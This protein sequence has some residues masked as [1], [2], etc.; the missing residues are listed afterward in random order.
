MSSRKVT[1]HPP[2]NQLVTGDFRKRHV[3]SSW[4]PRGT[5]D[6]VLT[7]TIAG[8]GRYGYVGGEMI[9]LP[10][11]L[12]LMRPGTL[13]DYGLEPKLRRWV[14]LWTHFHPRPHWIEWLHW[15]EIAPGLMRLSIE[16]LAARRRI[17]SRFHDVHNLA[18]GPLVRR[19][20]FAMNALEEVL[21]WCDVE[22]PLARRT[23]LDTRV[24]VAM[25]VLCHRLSEKITQTGLAETCGLSASRL[26]H[27]FRAQVGS[28]PQRFLELQRLN[29]AVQ[30]LDS[31]QLSVKE[32]AAQVGFDNPFYFTLRFKR[33]NGVSPR[34][35][36]LRLRGES[37]LEPR[38]RE[39]GREKLIFT[40][41][42]LRD[43]A[44][45]RLI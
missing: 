41:R 10:H 12:V 13:H 25:D 44:A 23:P 26:A 4:R 1:G 38:R 19:E 33:Q 3:Y 36:R 22:N 11:D 20:T 21:L 45:S 6:W 27:L 9:A 5:N 37:R 7:Y 42:Q 2:V 24:R 43:F 30:L 40:S 14:F 31:T 18:T 29:R 16:D 35:Y 17:A 15:P 8:R 34:D 28:T 32:I 39:E